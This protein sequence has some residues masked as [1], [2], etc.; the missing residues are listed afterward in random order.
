MA[1]L[2]ILLRDIKSKSEN[3]TKKIV[4]RTEVQDEEFKQIATERLYII[5]IELITKKL[6]TL[7]LKDKLNVHRRK[8]GVNS[9]IPWKYFFLLY[10]FAP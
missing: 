8:P 5:D 3:Q 7:I 6:I 4:Q 9:H 2:R 10:S 1:H